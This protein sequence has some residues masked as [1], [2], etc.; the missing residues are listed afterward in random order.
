MNITMNEFKK[1]YGVD[2]ATWTE[3]KERLLSG[4]SPTNFTGSRGNT[5]SEHSLLISPIEFIEENDYMQGE[6]MS[7]SDIEEFFEEGEVEYHGGD[8]TYNYGGL[9]EREL[10]WYEFENV[11]TGEWL[12]LMSFHVGL[13]IR[14]GYTNWFAMKFDSQYGFQ[15][16]LITSY[17]IAYIDFTIDG[18]KFGMS[19]SAEVASEYLNVYITDDNNNEIS[20]RYNEQTIDIDTY[21][22]ED[23]MK[24]VEVYLKENL[25]DFDEGSLVF[26]L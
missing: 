7:M 9:L 10:N 26:N 16:S 15:E 8:N 19:I 3:V 12:V 24:S 20:T 22:K 6:F 21:D 1:E 11:E 4:Q 13:D 2:L 14:S 23:L 25:I 17:E 5:L 18:E